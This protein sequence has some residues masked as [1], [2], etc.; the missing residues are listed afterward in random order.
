MDHLQA[1]APPGGQQRADLLLDDLLRP[2]LGLLDVMPVPDVDQDQHRLPPRDLPV[3][4][5]VAQ[6]LFNPLLARIHVPAIVSA[7]GRGEAVWRD[8]AALRHL[9][10]LR[11]RPSTPATPQA[12]DSFQ[13]APRAAAFCTWFDLR[14][15][16]SISI[17]SANGFNG[18]CGTPAFVVGVPLPEITIMTSP[19]NPSLTDLSAVTY[20]DHKPARP[21]PRERANTRGA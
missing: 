5:G 19:P 8:P 16:R 20:Q 18:K 12:T 14:N 17:I 13:N 1:A 4:E 9:P 21:I 11:A 3:Q 10:P 2:G 6:I 7:A 15:Q